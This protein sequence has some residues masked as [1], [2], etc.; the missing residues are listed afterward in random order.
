[1]GCRVHELSRDDARR[2]VVRA[3]LLDADRP[4]DVIEVAE[5]LGAVK[6]DP[7]ATIAPSEQ[8][9]PW[10]RIGWAYE[11]GQL[12]KAVEQ[13]RLLFEYDGHFRPASLLPA[14]LAR[15]R[16]RLF[17]AQASAWLEANARF[18]ADVLA[19]LRAEGPVL[20]A[21]IPDTSQVA[22]KNEA[23]WYGSNQVP[24]MLEL[25]SYV[26]ETAIVGR[27]GR[28]R[29]WDLG[30]R[31][32]ADVPVL[33]HDDAGEIL[34]QRRLQAAGIARQRSPWTPVGTAGE[35]ASV[36]G[37][38]W[39]WRVDPAALETLDDDPGGRVA[40]LNPYDGM[41]FDRP[42]L[43]E[44]FEFEYIL[45]QFKPKAQRRYGYFAH[46]ILLGDRFVG[47]LDAELDK[48]KETLV[49]TAVHELEDLDAE[50]R[51]MIDAEVRDLAEWLG[52]ALAFP[53]P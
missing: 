42:R 44:L 25:L 9:I 10:S 37:S 2:L 26:G 12:K 29:M 50:E 1:M 7:T 53:G 11:P 51:E 36:E 21:Q 45:E 33:D 13:D 43:Q 38:A 6:I 19:Q 48:K 47:L 15:M 5:Q 28:Q 27:E 34:D 3:Q 22:H 8:T 39:K 23:G 4:G 40:I 16:G 14:H 35:P 41:L 49:V 17:R 30:E 52:V 18:R 32:Y 31:V 24:R 20:A 46:P